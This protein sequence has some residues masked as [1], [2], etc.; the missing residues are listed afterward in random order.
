MYLLLHWLKHH[1]QSKRNNRFAMDLRNPRHSK[2]FALSIAL[3]KE[4]CSSK[5]SK[6]TFQEV[7]MSF[8]NTISTDCLQS[9]HFVKGAFCTY[10]PRLNEV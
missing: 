8:P 6:I 5:H 2:K 7:I 10:K 4:F 9:V 1:Q 3:L